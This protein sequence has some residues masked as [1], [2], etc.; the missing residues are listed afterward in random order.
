MMDITKK[1]RR[2][3]GGSKGVVY[4]WASRAPGLQMSLMYWSPRITS[5]ATS[6]PYFNLSP[7]PRCN[8][9]RAPSKVLSFYNVSLKIFSFITHSLFIYLN[10]PFDLIQYGLNHPTHSRGLHGSPWQLKPASS[11]CPTSK[12][13]SRLWP[14]NTDRLNEILDNL[15]P[16]EIRE[17]K[18]RFETM[19]FQCDLLGKLPFEL[20]AMLVKYL[21]LAD[22]VLLRR[23][24]HHLLGYLWHLL[25]CLY[26][27][28]LQTMACIALFAHRRHRCNQISHGKKRHQARFYP[29]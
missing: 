19:T 25:T 8:P 11:V 5:K 26:Y 10:L 9:G 13:Y 29:G 2:N 3:V 12:V 21:D 16:H 1:K 4:C 23:V 22:L 20:V 7:L 18:S 24:C 15:S 28:G 6:A 14:A 17:V 27:K